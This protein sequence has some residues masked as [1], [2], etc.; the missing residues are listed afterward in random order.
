MNAITKFAAGLLASS[1]CAPL[2]AAQPT[3]SDAEKDPVLAAMLTELDRSMSQLQL[4]DFQKPFFIQ[5]R[6]VDIDDFET[7]ASYGAP[8]G[9]GHNHARLARVTVLI[10]DYKTDSSS[11]RGDGAVELTALDN[12]PI[13]LRSSLWMATDQ[14][15]KAALAAFAQKQAALKQVQTPPQADDLSHEKALISLAEPLTLAVDAKQESEW[16]R[17]VAEFSGLY[18]SNASVSSLEPD[19]QTSSAAFHARVTTSRLVNSEGTIVRKSDASYLE[20]FGVGSQAADGMRIDRSRSSNG[21]VLADLES[22][23]VFTKNAVRLIAS[24]SELRQAPVVEEEYHG[25][26]LLSADAATDTLRRLL[27]SAITATRPGLGTEARTNGPFASSFHARVLPDFLNVVDDPTLKTYN[28]KQ[29][30]GAFDV[31]DEGVPAQ[32]V[33]VITDGKLENYLIGRE[34]VRDF[35]QSNGHGRAALSGPAHPSVGVL[36]IT[37]KDGLSDDDLQKKLLDIAKDRELKSVYYV[38]TLGGPLVPRLLYRISADGKRELVRGARL[39]D[40]D[41]RALRSSVEAAGKD[42]WLGNFAGDIPETV[43][44]PALLVDDV[45]IRRANEKNDKLPFYPPPE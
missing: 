2:F 35:P 24:L 13:A 34:P 40:L 26:V 15:Y 18:R 36:K 11:P 38:E 5:Y 31:D 27:A 17:R 25:P 44:A 29:L 22:P 39:A 30:V 4:K 32:A 20:S 16:S 23:E 14:A 19:I 12:D 10:G 3:R 8:E 28:S 21:S 37:A 1:L 45:T 43:L 9:S 42:L 41:Q 33:P 7:R 6:I